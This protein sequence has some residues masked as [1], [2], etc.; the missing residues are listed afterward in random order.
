MLKKNRVLKITVFILIVGSFLGCNDINKQAQNMQNSVNQG[1]D[2]SKKEIKNIGDASKSG[3]KNIN[4]FSN[5]DI[6]IDATYIINN[7]NAKGFDAKKIQK[8][9]KSY[10]IFFSV[11]Q[12]SV[13]LNGGYISIYQYGNN[14]KQIMQNDFNTMN[15]KGY[16]VNRNED[17]WTLNFHLFR[18]GR[19]FLVYDGSDTNIL[20]ALNEILGNQV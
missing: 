10:D 8:T 1:A 14:D 13:Q 18:K 12:E 7:L 16:I 15:E 11:P 2:N 19:V 6:Q 17:N 9:D 20:R 5:E 3:E 4:T